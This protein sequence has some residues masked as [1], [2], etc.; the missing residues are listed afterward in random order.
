MLNNDEKEELKFY[1]LRL[2]YSLGIFLFFFIV[3]FFMIAAMDNIS[4]SIF[5]KVVVFYFIITIIIELMLARKDYKSTSR[6]MGFFLFWL[7]TT[8]FIFTGSFFT[9]NKYII[10]WQ[11]MPNI[12]MYSMALLLF[13][14]ALFYYLKK[15]DFI[16]AAVREGKLDIEQRIYSVFQKDHSKVLKQSG[17]DGALM[18]LLAVITPVIGVSI[19]LILGFDINEIDA[20][21]II[22]GVV[23]LISLYPLSSWT[24]KELARAIQFYQYQKKSRKT[25]YTGLIKYI[26][27][28]EEINQWR[29]QKGLKPLKIKSLL[30]FGDIDK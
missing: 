2:K 12:V 19:I 26:R 27:R 29:K 7:S 5:L 23:L 3:S 13:L 17:R 18:G 20:K 10:K 30:F 25:I 21:Q 1:K 16:D 11:I 24:A 4:E 22:R 8:F 14:W 9:V 6:M 28:E 15:V